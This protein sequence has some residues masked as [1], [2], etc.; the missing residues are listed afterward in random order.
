M[1]RHRGPVLIDTNAILECFRVG[2]WRALSNG[3]SV[4]TVEDCVTE[5]QTGFQRRRA[6]LQ[7]DAAQLVASLK[8]VHPVDGCA[9]RR[10]GG[11]SARHRAGRRR[12]IFVGA[13]ADAKRCLGSLRA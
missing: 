10:R 4:E 2:S 12:A 6:E 13:C 3:Y 7:I 9:A 1:A 8:A 11:S 5:T